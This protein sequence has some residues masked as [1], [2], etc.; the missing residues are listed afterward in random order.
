MMNLNNLQKALVQ[1]SPRSS[2]IATSLSIVCAFAFTSSTVWASDNVP[3][4]AQKNPLV[5]KG[6]TIHTVS[7]GDIANGQIVIEKGRITALGTNPTVPSNAKV[8]DVTGKHI[9]PGMIAA[10]TVIGIAEVQSVRATADFAEAGAINPNARAI[11]AVNPDSELIPVTR[12]NGVLAALSV[13]SAGPAGMINGTSALVQLDGWTWEDMTV[14][15]EVG[16]HISVPFMRF[17]PELFPPPLDARLDEL[18][19]T[20]AQ[21][22]KM[23]E[24]AFDSA[25]AYR[26]ARA[27]KD[28]TQ[29]DVRWEAMLPVLAG[30]RPVFMHAQDAAQIRF[31]L[32]FA[33]RY[34]LKLVVVG[35]MDAPMFADT[36]RDR[37]V[38]VIITGIH[39]LPQRRG[40]EYDDAYRLASKLS[41]AG[42]SFCIARGGADDDAHNERNLP[43]EA[44]VAVSFGL[45]P[46]EAL[47]AVTLYPAQILGVADKLGSLEVGK[48]ANL[49]VSDGNPMETMTKIEQVFIQ[50][51]PVD[52]TT[53]QSR[54]TEKY[55]QKYI[56]KK[57]SM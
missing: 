3:A 13:P 18:R 2:L 19:K 24:D 47:K 30:K 28:G 50:G 35:G 36:L 23:L 8:I 52:L 32:N 54:L 6:A 29:I 11:V 22:V 44:A 17:N 5:F 55:Q 10:N 15:A 21:R 4:P 14:Q 33:Q 26:D 51:R 39:K 1:Q 42:V 41:L 25:I 9:Y 37:K 31:A 7:N 20:S 34:Q 12:V 16:L 57:E 43:Y 46:N 49:F 56:Q 38:P 40:A 27:A 53:K 48:F 45:D